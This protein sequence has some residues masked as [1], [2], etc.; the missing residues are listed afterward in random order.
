MS[1]DR[2][3]SRFSDGIIQLEN[4]KSRIFGARMF[5]TSI[6]SAV[7]QAGFA[8]ERAFWEAA[9]SF[10]QEIHEVAD[11]LSRFH[12]R[13]E[14]SQQLAIDAAAKHVSDAL[15]RAKAA[16]FDFFLSETHLDARASLV[17]MLSVPKYRGLVPESART[18]LEKPVTSLAHG[19]A[20]PSIIIKKKAPAKKKTTPLP[21]RTDVIDA[22]KKLYPNGPPAPNRPVIKAAVE[23][24]L[25]RVV[26][27]RTID[28]ARKEAW[29]SG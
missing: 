2:P 29:P 22:L 17:W 26:S 12:A 7:K 11:L 20:N 16:K 14:R 25:G 15:A 27:D 8:D 3:N 18:F 9:L 24:I 19:D 1:D 10:P 6:E 4:A 5:G 23:K 28:R 13:P 21:Q